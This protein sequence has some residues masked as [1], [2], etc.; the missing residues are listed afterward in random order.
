MLAHGSTV[1]LASMRQHLYRIVRG[2]DDMN[3]SVFELQ[4]LRSACPCQR[5][6]TMIYYT[7][8]FC[9]GAIGSSSILFSIL[10]VEQPVRAGAGRSSMLSGFRCHDG[11]G[12]SLFTCRQQARASR[13][14]NRRRDS[15]AFLERFA[16]SLTGYPDLMTRGAQRS[17]AGRSR[18]PRVPIWLLLGLRS[19]WPRPWI[20]EVRS[21]ILDRTL[22]AISRQSPDCTTEAPCLGLL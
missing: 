20:S 3:N 4:R 19:A 15:A 14:D 16:Y 13:L 22:E 6:P 5:T 18:I 1:Q 9:V 17:S 2:P 11:V 10:I 12:V 8:A 21:D 7:S